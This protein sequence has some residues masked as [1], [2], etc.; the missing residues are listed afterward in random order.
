MQLNYEQ[1][2]ELIKTLQHT[3][4]KPWGILISIFISIITFYPV[5]KKIS[6]YNTFSDFDSL[7]IS[8]H[9]VIMQ[10]T[11]KTL[12]TF[13][14]I[15]TAYIFMGLLITAGIINFQKIYIFKGLINWLVL[16]ALLTFALSL[17]PF[18]LNLFINTYFSTE[19]QKRVR[20]NRM[21]E[22]K[23]MRLNYSVNNALSF[24]TEGILIYTLINS[25]KMNYGI[26]FSIFIFPIVFLYTYRNYNNVSKK[27]TNYRVKIIN[28]DEFNNSSPILKYTLDA[29]R[30]VFISSVNEDNSYYV[31]E[32]QNDKYYKYIPQE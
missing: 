30:I 18:L 12:T 26:L 14:L 27:E 13:M 16:V 3:F 21:K 23:F 25:D 32:R 17:I 24:F 15:I 28:E 20:F 4:D 29:D 10:K 22:N 5:F 9:E 31:L 19:N 2:S 11:I 8:K 6:I 1:G 7:F